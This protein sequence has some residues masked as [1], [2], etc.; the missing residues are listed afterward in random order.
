MA[1]KKHDGRESG[2]NAVLVLFPLHWD[3]DEKSFWRGE[4]RV[5]EIG[6]R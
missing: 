6:K 5:V 1:W 4:S 3:E 2:W